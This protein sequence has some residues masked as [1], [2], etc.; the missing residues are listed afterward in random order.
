LEQQS[1]ARPQQKVINDAVWGS[2][3]LDPWEVGVLDSPLM[4][5]LRGLRQLGVIHWV[6]PNAGHSRLEH[7]IGVVHQVQGLIDGIERNSGRAGQ[8]MVDDVSTKLMRLAGLVHDCGH[9]IMSH[10]SESFISKLAGVE[11]LCRW[12][13]QIYLPR[14]KPSASEAFAAIFVRSPA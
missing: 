13:H 5:R 10:V 2:I 4:Q 9:T 1:L 8:R 6:Y 14:K 3:R 11:E 12:L 7:S